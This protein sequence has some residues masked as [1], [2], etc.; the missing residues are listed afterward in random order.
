MGL[1]VDPSSKFDTS[2]TDTLQNHLFEVRLG[3][4]TVFAIDLVAQNINR[5][6]DH[7]I[8]DYNTVREKCG[9][10]RANSFQDLRDAISD[11]K[12]QRLASIYE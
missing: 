9:L 4:G 8:P 6:R 7:G 3:D 5:G 10:R 12:I 2:V 1:T 11:D